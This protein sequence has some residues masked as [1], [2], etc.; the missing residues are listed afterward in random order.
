MT[1]TGALLALA[2][3]TLEFRTRNGIVHVLEDVSF[4]IA[5]GEMLGLVGESGSGKSVTA[6]AILG[7]LDPSARIRSGTAMFEGVDLFAATD[8][9]LQQFRGSR[10]G[11]IFQ[12]PRSALNPIR[13]V[14]QQIED[15]LIAHRLAPSRKA[16]RES[17]VDL[18]AQVSIPDPERRMSAYPSELSG[19]MCQRVLIA[20]ALAASPALLIADEP[21]T[22][23]DVTTQAL[24]M[25]LINNLRARRRMATLLISHDLGLASE[26]CDR[27]VVMHAGHVVECAKTEVLFMNPLHPYTQRL[28]A[29][30]PTPTV[31]LDRMEP[32]AGNIPDLRGELP[33][34]RFSRRCEIYDG[35]CDRA[36][37]RRVTDEEGHFVA[38]WKA[39]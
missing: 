36:P 12:N 10:I 24:I 27:I 6:Y 33:P 38:C 17:V 8:E 28:I 11:M 37:L 30:T 32:I 3:V 20:L 2:D 26:H 14:G 35:G 1:E 15:V 13:P 23:L 25:E 21:T 22:G 7:L 18:L 5:P 19:G 39:L 9:Q 29:A 34:C 31:T 4:D 16:A